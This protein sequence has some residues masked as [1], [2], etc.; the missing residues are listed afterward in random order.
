M[1]Q[2]AIGAAED[3]EKVPPHLPSHTSFPRPLPPGVLC[4]YL[5]RKAWRSATWLPLSISEGRHTA[6][7]PLHA[8]GQVGFG[9]FGG[10]VIKCKVFQGFECLRVKSFHCLPAFAASFPQTG[11]M[12]AAW[13][14]LVARGVA[15]TTAPLPPHCLPPPLPLSARLDAGGSELFGRGGKDGLLDLLQVL[16]G[17]T[18]L[19]NDAHQ[20]S[21][22]VG[23]CV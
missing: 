14:C 11:W 17:G 3:R 23:V 22:C 16:G 8:S 10:W 21:G 15:L 7:C 2:N 9:A 13:S 5:G 20:V 18:L 19:I 4:C 6:C 12:L 1:R